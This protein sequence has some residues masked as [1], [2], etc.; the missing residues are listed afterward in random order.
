MAEIFTSP[1][2]TPSQQVQSILEEIGLLFQSVQKTSKRYELAAKPDDLVVG[3][4]GDVKPVVRQ[5]HGHLRR[6]VHQRQKQTSLVKKAA[7]ALYVKKDFDRL[8]EQI[9]GFV[10]DLETIWPVEATRRQ[11]ARLEIEGVDAEPALAAVQDAAARVDSV[12][13]EAAEHKTEGITGKNYAGKI[14]TQDEARVR[15]GNEFAE[16]SL[17]REGI[18]DQTTNTADTVRPR[19]VQGPRRNELLY[20]VRRA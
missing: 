5:L 15:V 7:W 18:A 17:G 12:L 20:E 1:T 13:A 16:N 8:V 10:D 4:D 3:L 11:L 14:G 6:M 2:D 19:R 9:T